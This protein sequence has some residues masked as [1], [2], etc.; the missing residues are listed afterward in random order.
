MVEVPIPKEKWSGK[1]GTV[2]LG[3][4]PEEGG[5][6]AARLVIGGEVAMPFLSFEGATPNR[7]L[8]AGEV[9]DQTND[10]S[11][12]VRRELGASIED[13][14]AWARMWVEEFH[15]DLICL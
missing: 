14:V 2:A 5:T 6:R 11:D 13:P 4:T 8:I 7:P 10:L 1:I 9:I 12:L 15:A 3:A